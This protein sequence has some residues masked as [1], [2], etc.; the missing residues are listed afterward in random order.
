ME[1]Q[2]DKNRTDGESFF[3]NAFTGMYDQNGKPIHEGDRV[4]FY[5]KGEYITCQVVYDARNAA[6][7]IKWPDGYVNQYF[8]N[9]SSYEIVSQ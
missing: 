2:T 7:L 5:Y 1:D 3:K 8:M 4:K 9:G 6:F